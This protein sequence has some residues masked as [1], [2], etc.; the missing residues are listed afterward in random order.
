MNPSESGIDSQSKG[1]QISLPI[2]QP[3]QH[4]IYKVE[5]ISTQT[6]MA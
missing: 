3:D 1:P 2:N 5:H 6:D 4:I